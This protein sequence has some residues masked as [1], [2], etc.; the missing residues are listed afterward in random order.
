MEGAFF[1]NSGTE[2]NE[3]AIKL[4]RL[5]GAR[6]GIEAPRVAVVDGAFHGRTLAS[7]AATA[8]AKAQAGFAPLPTGFDRVP[9]G[10]IPA[11]EHLVTRSRDIAA[12]LVEPIQGEGGV[13]PAPDGYLESLRS[14]CDDQGILLMLDE[15]Q[16][17]MGRSGRWFAHQHAGIKPD[18]MTLAKALANGVPIGACLARGE[19]AELFAP[20]SH[21]STFG[22]NPLACT[23]ALA[24]LNA[25][26]KEGLCERAAVLGERILGGLRSRLG[27]LPQV[28]EIRGI[29]LM[30]GIE[31][32]R[33][34]AAL[35]QTALSKRLL[36]NVT[37]ETVVRLLP[38]LIL[39]DEE[40]DRI[41]KETAALITDFL[42]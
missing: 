35:V 2:A 18:V 26:E 3:A 5:H 11:L 23:A 39:T 9:F 17:G 28:R 32:D 42:N 10:D 37:A 30:I 34:C 33:P 24:V 8:S 40:A 29:G 15:I 41:T 27:A 4:A 16:C 38:P 6:R 1:C 14:L 22:G 20:G 36:L 31:L 25:I 12:V 19:A 21:G 13:R 7:L